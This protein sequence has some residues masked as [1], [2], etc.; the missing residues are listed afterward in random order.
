[1]EC[2]YVG[3]ALGLSGVSSSSAAQVSFVLCWFSFIKK[4]LCGSG[5]AQCVHMQRMACLFV[6]FANKVIR[7]I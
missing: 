7:N 4:P 1:M 5:V 2:G 6:I 3:E